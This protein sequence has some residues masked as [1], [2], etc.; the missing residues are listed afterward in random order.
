MFFFV[1]KMTKYLFN[2]QYKLIVSDMR[3]LTP[4]CSILIVFKDASLIETCG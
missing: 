4:A 1:L 2:V 3:Y